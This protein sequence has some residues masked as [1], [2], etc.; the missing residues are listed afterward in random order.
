MTPLCHDACLL[1]QWVTNGVLT[2]L[3]V[4]VGPTGNWGYPQ[5]SANSSTFADYSNAIETTGETQ[6]DV[7]L[8]R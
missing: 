7:V 3:C 1:V 4:D 6:F 2:L 8:V 5:P